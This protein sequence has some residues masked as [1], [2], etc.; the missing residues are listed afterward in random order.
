MSLF[1]FEFGQTFLVDGAAVA[2]TVV[3]TVPG[4]VV[5]AV[6][7]VLA[8]RLESELPSSVPLES[9]SLSREPA[10]TMFFRFEVSKNTSADRM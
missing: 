1:L 2:G 3:G 9:F 4:F 6:T 10:I 8:L 7:V 5:C